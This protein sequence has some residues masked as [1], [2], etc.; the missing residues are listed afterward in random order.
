MTRKEL[1]EAALEMVITAD[2]ENLTNLTV[3]EIARRLAV[4][5]PNLSRAF[6]KHYGT[7]KR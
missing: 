3:S 5:L 2:I 1:A 4:S 7:I 6:H